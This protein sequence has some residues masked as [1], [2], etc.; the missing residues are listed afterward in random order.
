MA[1]LSIQCPVA[2]AA[3]VVVCLGW[4]AKTADARITRIEI[5]SEAP[6]FGG[7]TFGSV[8]A[9]V[10]VVGKA[11]GEVDPGL[12]QNA[13]IQDIQLAPKNKRGNVEYVTDVAFLKPA[14]LAKGNGV[15]IAQGALYG[16]PL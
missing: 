1:F 11:Y 6:A 4:G 12:P 7:K 15:Q 14:D 10:R 5:T 2:C 13:I 16:I 3:A 8:G 9:Y